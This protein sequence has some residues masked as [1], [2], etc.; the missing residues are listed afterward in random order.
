M[1]MDMMQDKGQM[2]SMDQAPAEDSGYEICIRVDGQGKISVGVE[3]PG[4][5]MAESDAMDGEMEDKG[6]T[7]VDSWPE[8]LQIVQDIYKNAGQMDQ[9]SPDEQLQ[10]GYDKAR[11][12]MQSKMTPKR[13]FGD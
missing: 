1:A 7:P 6:Y 10:A 8:A 13:V 4:Q 3:T 11:P 5:E 12:M 2:S 9:R